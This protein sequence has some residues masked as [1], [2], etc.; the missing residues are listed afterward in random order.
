MT[1]LKP[2]DEPASTPE[3]LIGVVGPCGSG[4]STLTAGLTRLGY[5]AR[6]IAQ[7]H[8]YVKDMWQRLT[9]PDILIFLDA[10]WPSTCQRRKLDW[11]EAEWQEQQNRL[12]HAR[13]NTDLFLDT[14]RLSIDEV[15]FQVIKFISQREKQEK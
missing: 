13:A 6:H 1:T 10:S 15:L 2:K 11:T 14:D 4:K 7:E 9:K 5:R 12:S 3:L 8:S